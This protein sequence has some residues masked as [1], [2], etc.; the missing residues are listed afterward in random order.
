[1][2][3]EEIKIAVSQQAFDFALAKHD[4]YTYLHTPEEVRDGSMS[5]MEAYVTG[6]RAMQ[7]LALNRLTFALMLQ[8]MNEDL[9]F[10][11]IRDA[12]LSPEIFPSRSSKHPLEKWLEED[13]SD[14]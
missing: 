9:V 13:T 1:M 11:I 14:N 10:G 4:A 8:G 7:E 3:D 6:A 2:P 5:V 12:K